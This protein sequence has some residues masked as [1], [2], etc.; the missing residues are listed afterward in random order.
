[1]VIVKTKP[2][3][4]CS[5]ALYYPNDGIPF[6]YQRQRVEHTRI[7]KNFYAKTFPYNKSNA[8]FWKGLLSNV[9]Y[10][11]AA[12]AST[13]FFV[14]P[15]EYVRTRLTNDIQVVKEGRKRQFEGIIDCWRKTIAWDG[16]RG[17]YRGF[18]VSCAFTMIYRGI[19][20]GL[21]DSISSP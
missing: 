19:Y 10:G 4:S 9:I 7:R 12:A 3:N 13:Q 2:I 18:V 21:N 17:V 8:S 1:M 11:S 20:F 6:L 14:Y 5:I 15:I 16:I